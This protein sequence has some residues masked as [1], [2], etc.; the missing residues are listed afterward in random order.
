MTITFQ[1]S[2][3]PPGVIIQCKV[4]GNRGISPPGSVA[5]PC[6]WCSP[7]TYV[8]ECDDHIE[9]GS[10]HVER[11]IVIQSYTDMMD[12]VDPYP[13]TT[14]PLPKVLADSLM[15]N[16]KGGKKII[17]VPHPEPVPLTNAVVTIEVPEDKRAEMKKGDS[18][19][20]DDGT[21]VGVVLEAADA[22]G[23]ATIKLTPY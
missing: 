1:I 5:L 9:L 11:V 15:K 22:N 12:A 6:P 2:G 16:Y 14:K 18:L 10:A 7:Y 8:K 20:S 21:I 13:G 23:L 17:L 19:K 4:C 3:R